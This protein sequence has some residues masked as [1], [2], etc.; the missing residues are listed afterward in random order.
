MKYRIVRVKYRDLTECSKVKTSELLS[1]DLKILEIYGR[2]VPSEDN[3]IRI[4]KEWDFLED[5]SDTE[6]QLMIIPKS[7]VIE[8]EFLDRKI[9]PKKRKG[10]KK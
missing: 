7:V 2:L 10:K 1:R 6:H 4:V 3:N 8:R 9:K 5:D